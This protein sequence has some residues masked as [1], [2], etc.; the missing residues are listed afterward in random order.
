[1]C[2]EQKGKVFTQM[3]I[4]RRDKIGRGGDFLRYGALKPFSNI[5]GFT[6]GVRGG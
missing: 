1:M 4:T 6:G 5:G 3:M 2:P